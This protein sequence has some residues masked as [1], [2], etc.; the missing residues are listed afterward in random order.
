MRSV[1]SQLLKYRD[2]FSG[3]L[4]EAVLKDTRVTTPRGLILGSDEF[5][6]QVA[7]LLGR[8]VEHRPIGRPTKK[9]L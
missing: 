6:S 9:R 4:D 3:K 2:L 7:E 5:R 8:E 1:A